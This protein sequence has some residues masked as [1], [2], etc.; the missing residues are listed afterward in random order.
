MRLNKPGSWQW[1][2]ML[3]ALLVG[4]SCSV[5]ATSN[6]AQGLVVAPPKAI[7]AHAL[8]NQDARTLTFPTPGKWQLA[9]FGFTSCPDV[10]PVTLQKATKV[11]KLLGAHASELEMV[12]LSIDS[13]RDQPEVLKKFV[14]AHD[15]RITGLTG[16]EGAVQAVAN[17][18]GVIARRYQG[19]TALA[20]RIEHSSFLYLLDPQGRIVMFYP[21]KIGAEQVATD[22]VRLS[23]AVKKSE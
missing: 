11:L 5:L 17:E 21:E 3:T 18:F 9:F 14:D 10:C 19:K 23:A 12:F 7:P 13:G 22:F 15:K 2:V 16:P 6:A 1:R 8:L 4:V 20:Y